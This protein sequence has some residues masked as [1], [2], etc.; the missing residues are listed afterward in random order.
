VVS[1]YIVEET[2]VEALHVVLLLHNGGI[3]DLLTAPQQLVQQE[4]NTIVEHERKKEAKED[5]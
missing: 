4:H 5:H 2:I 3:T 1:T